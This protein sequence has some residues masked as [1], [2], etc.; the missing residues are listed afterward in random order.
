MC[1]NSFIMALDRI[2]V[3][4]ETGMRIFQERLSRP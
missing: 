3:N 1:R 2:S 4:S